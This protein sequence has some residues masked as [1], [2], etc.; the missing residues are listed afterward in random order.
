MVY[1]T[2]KAASGILG[3]AVVCLPISNQNIGCRSDADGMSIVEPGGNSMTNFRS[4]RM[5]WP[6][7]VGLKLPSA[8]MAH[9]PK[10]R[11]P[12]SVCGY[13][14]VQGSKLKVKQANMLQQ[15]FRFRLGYLAYSGRR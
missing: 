15:K 5:R 13:V 12:G 2:K 14:Q 1:P 11:F 4:Q 3:K 10:G 8:I 7:R 9:Q 6:L